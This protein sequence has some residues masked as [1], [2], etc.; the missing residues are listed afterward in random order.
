MVRQHILSRFLVWF[1]MVFSLLTFASVTWGADVKLLPSL[2][3]RGEYNDNVTFSRKAEKDDF[4]GTA[5]PSITFGYASELATLKA[6]LGADF[7]GYADDDNLNT[8]NQRY[9]VDGAYQTTERFKLLGDLSY[10]K[11]TTL[12]SELEETGLVVGRNDRKRLGG[13]AGAVYRLNEVSDVGV[14]V[15]YTDVN[16]DSS[17]FVDY[18]SKAVLL[19][20]NHELKESRD[21]LTVQT[22]YNYSTS[23]VSK[24][25]NYG[26]S[27][28]LSHAF[29]E[30]LRFDGSI[31]VRYTKTDFRLIRSEILVDPA[32]GLL[33]FSFRR[34][35]QEEND[36]GGTAHL[37]LTR[38][39]ETTSWSA[40]YSRDLTY[41]PYG[42]P[43]ETDRFYGRAGWKVTERLDAGIAGSLY[44][45][46]SQGTVGERDSRYFD[47]TPSLK[48]RITEDH[49]LQCAYSYSRDE[50]NRL[51][52]DKTAERNRVWLM[53]VFRFK[54]LV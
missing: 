5:S 6:S 8:V 13:G 54:D 16:Y 25:D 44:F 23:D 4:I 27:F 51:T 30:K 32:T 22:V 33:V 46:K 12:D 17:R 40:G 21:V 47:L 28:G 50:D 10:V 52:S 29:S 31:G 53:L 19:T 11:D 48:Y 35:N 20:Y 1:L 15:D 9:K 26:L 2:A 7:M 39:D 34:E 37:S 41:G 18:T 43:I 36:W 3:L 45:T 24:V 42:E 49:F 14:K 38:Q